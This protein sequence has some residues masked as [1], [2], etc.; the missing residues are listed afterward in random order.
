[1]RYADMLELY[2]H[3][4]PVYDVTN[5]VAG[6]WKS[7]IPNDQF[8]D[9]LQTTLNALDS[10]QP[11]DR[12]A[13]WMQGPYGTGKTHAMAVIKHLLCDPLAEIQEYLSERL[14]HAQLRERLG[15][16]RQTKRIF[17]VVLK[18][19]SNIMDNRTFA[20]VIERA[21]KQA[22]Q[23]QQIRL[24]T[25]SDF[26]KMAAKIT[27]KVVNWE[28]LI[29][30][31][32][33]LASYVVDKNDLLNRLQ[34]Q[35]IDIFRTVE[36]ILSQRGIHFSHDNI[37]IWL[38]QVAGELQKQGVAHTLMLFWDEFTNL[39]ELGAA[40]E[41]LTE[42]Q[43]V[44]ELS[45]NQQVSLFVINHRRPAQS[46]ITQED[47]NKIL[48]RFHDKSYHMAPVTTYHIVAAAI[49][50]KDAAGWET[51]KKRLMDDHRQLD[52][53]IHRLLE[54]MES[55]AAI[56]DIRALFP[57]H[58][59]TAY[60][61]TFIARNLGSTERSIFEFLYDTHKG[62]LR[63][64]AEHPQ[65][66]GDYYLTAD[67]LWDYFA[68]EFEKSEKFTFGAILEKYKLH[69][70]DVQ[71]RGAACFAIFKGV[72]LLN[73]LS[74]VTGIEERGKEL[75]A[76]SVDNVASMFLGT[77]YEASVTEVLQIL[78]HA[79]IQKTPDNFFFV[80]TTSLPLKEIEEQKR[81]LET[82]Y[83]EVVNLLNP[84]QKQ[85]L[86]AALS[87][88]ILREVEMNLYWAGMAEHV[89]RS[90]LH[91]A[92]KTP[93]ALHVALFLMREESERPQS[94]TVIEKLADE[95]DH[96][97]FVLIDEALE[98]VKFAKFLEYRARAEV[99][100]RHSYDKEKTA[101]ENYAKQIIEKWLTTIKNGLI[102]LRWK[103]KTKK[104]IAS[105]FSYI[106]N[107][108]LSP[109][110]FP[111]GLETLKELQENQNV[112]KFQ[113]RAEK[114]VEA[115]LTDSR[116]T[117]EE[118]T[119]NFPYKNL[120]SIVKD[121]KGNYIIDDKLDLK[122][123][124]SDEH[125]L[126]RIAAAVDD[127]IKNSEQFQIGNLLE[128]LTNSPYGLYSNSV[129][130][131]ALSFVLGRYVGKLYEAGSGRLVSRQMMRDKVH[132]LF[133][134]WQE[135]KEGEKLQL[136]YGTLEEKMLTGELKSLFGLKEQE[137]LTNVRWGIRD[138][139]KKRNYPLWVFAPYAIQSV[140]TG[141]AEIVWLTTSIDKDILQ[142]DILR[143]LQA[144][145]ACKYDLQQT[146]QKDARANFIVWLGEIEQLDNPATVA[147]AIYAY[148]QQNMQEEIPS[149]NE[150]KA[151][152]KVKDWQLAQ[153]RQV[154]EEKKQQERHLI[155]RLRNIFGL[156]RADNLREVQLQIRSW[157]EQTMYPLWVFKSLVSE[158][159]QQAIDEIIL[160]TI[161]MDHSLSA[162]DIQRL[163]EIVTANYVP[164]KATLRPEQARYAFIEW[165]KQIE[166]LPASDEVVAEISQYLNTT[167]PR[168]VSLWKEDEVKERIKAWQLKKV[169]EEKEQRQHLEHLLVEKF[170]GIFELQNV[171]SLHDARMKIR[172][173]IQNTYTPLW[174]FKT[175]ACSLIKTAID[176][177]VALS[178]TLDKEMTLPELTRTVEALTVAEDELHALFQQK[179]HHKFVDWLNSIE[180]VQVSETR[181][182]EIYRYLQGRMPAEIPSW[183]EDKAREA[184]K[185][186]R[187]DD[188]KRQEQERASQKKLFTDK[189]ASFF[190][191]GNVQSLDTLKQKI[192]T[193]VQD[194]HAPLWAFKTFVNAE[195]QAAI[196]VI[197]Q[198][199]H[200]PQ[201][202][203]PIEPVLQVLQAVEP[204]EL[205]L[206]LQKE[207][208]QYGF[209]QWLK[210]LE[211]V[212]VSDENFPRIV[213]YLDQTLPK[214]VMLWEEQDVREKVKDWQNAEL[215]R[216]LA[217]AQQ[218]TSTQPPKVSVV[219]ESQQVQLT[220]QR[221]RE[222]RGDVK[223]LLLK[224]IETHP[225]LCDTILSYL[226]EDR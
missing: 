179:A 119:Q 124:A 60:L 14:A 28:T 161:F 163:L 152:E 67:Y 168:K 130:M 16:F 18:G 192:Q 214:T 200:T 15:R 222:Y 191:F 11:K 189:L 82:T 149:W 37:S 141:L 105:T 137:G 23:Q 102:E 5:E 209:K 4:Q 83:R 140:K 139:I 25:S 190:G 40:K 206:K 116:T 131:A 203:D 61:A 134:Y 109:A 71:Q 64:I 182:P 169:E 51:L 207:R 84:E 45:V 147:D 36:I 162:E 187:L 95:F 96:V 115:F 57:I 63:F 58:P 171:E 7:F 184:V 80:A 199:A 183:D 20:L 12:K 118:K 165:L 195:M 123:E 219:K 52:R 144:I 135:R 223:P 1:M 194:A 93:Y 49:R 122:V 107:K 167:I 88:G 178:I 221:V 210:Q 41:L 94:R 43:H 138:W 172:D 114:A 98:Q 68:E 74:Q 160:I 9:I 186:W 21:V 59:Y 136:R 108:E 158:P 8:Y 33:E 77:Q 126:K 125:P 47:F 217:E 76:P 73:V 132:R 90:R 133:K 42:L 170:T 112:W 129:N 185:D 10:G 166:H 153:I 30:E 155:D 13:I 110:I 175:S 2:E 38:T 148:L 164:L 56:K 86:L 213:S 120:R 151:R 201:A 69:A 216:K 218:Q 220:Q 226:R 154:E 181:F 54:G 104:N 75:V 81:Q 106:V 66:E 48:G 193:W 198:A 225:D 46:N 72:L 180:Q 224:L 29:T 117:F 3:F 26:E 62:F 92:F 127:A 101:N 99:A 156:N 34:G 143:V 128:F 177:I 55:A 146:L 113:R 103:T 208:A 159:E 85:E 157:I 65:A 174:V 22:L 197:S 176:A 212:D 35:D 31:H 150:Q 202:P 53:L 50:K 44:A 32:P 205:R 79:Y 196:D 97:I 204:A 27:E 121:N 145:K 78:D 111:Y 173:W 215:K 24:S 17:P 100:A 211:Q 6:H 87:N 39:L 188:L 70:N 19:V 89:L 91:N 142:Q